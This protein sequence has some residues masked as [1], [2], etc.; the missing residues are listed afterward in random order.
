M[1]RLFNRAAVTV[2]TVAV[3]IVPAN[4]K[5][6]YLAISQ[7][8]ANAIRVGAADVTATTGVK[9]VEN[10]RIVFDG[11]HVPTDAIYAIRDGAADGTVSSIEVA[12]S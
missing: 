2:S 10:D 3:Q 4:T 11:D 6:R 7:T 5:R 12:E 9:L 8:S 1:A